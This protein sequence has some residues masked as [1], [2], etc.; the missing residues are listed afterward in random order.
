MKFVIVQADGIQGISDNI[1]R[2]IIILSGVKSRQMKSQYL[3]GVNT[4]HCN[5]LVWIWLPVFPCQV[6][7]FCVYLIGF[8]EKENNLNWKGVDFSWNIES[9]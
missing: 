6:A 3:L 2:A 4:F 7:L 5:I 1:V 8:R 9:V